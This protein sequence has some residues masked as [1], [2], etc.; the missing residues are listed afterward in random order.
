VNSEQS[1]AVQTALSRGRFE[2]NCPNA[3]GEV[4]SRNLLNP[5][6]NGPIDAG[7]QRAEYT[8]GVAG[9]GQRKVYFSVCQIGSVSCIA[10]ASR[11]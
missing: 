2:M 10:A 8:I 3:T 7:V 1:S 9:C 11:N 5:A 4:L 6:I